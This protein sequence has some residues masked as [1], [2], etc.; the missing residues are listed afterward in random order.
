MCGR[1]YL[2]NTIE[3]KPFLEKMM[4]SPLVQRWNGTSAVI[5]SGEI[6]PTDVVP[7]IA[8]NRSGNQSVFPMKWG[9]NGKTLLINARVETAR[10]KPTF[11][12]DWKSHRCIVPASCY[13]E[14]EHLKADGGKTKTGDKYIIQPQNS[15]MT[16]LCG[17]YRLENEMP[18]FVILT[19]DASDPIRFIHDR[20]PL[21]MPEDKINEWIKPDADPDVLLDYALSDMM[22]ERAQVTLQTQG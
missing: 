16:W 2:E 18:H 20:M 9:Y 19:R 21:I 6:H 1:Y 5:S 11:R 13:F 17:L 8:S 12:D 3:M 7:V 14:W 15:A 22:S 4:E 10:E